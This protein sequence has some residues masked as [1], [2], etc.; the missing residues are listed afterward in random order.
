[1]KAGNI[2][3]SWPRLVL[4]A[5]IIPILCLSLS[6]RDK[7]T[8]TYAKSINFSNF[9]TYSWAEHGA[10]AHPL[11]AADIVAAIE[12]ELNARGLRK[13]TSNPDLIIQM[14]GSID[15]DMTMYS[16]DPLYG[17]TGGIP[18]FDPNLAGPVFIGFYGNTTVTVHKGQLVVDLIDA[19][20]KKLVWRGIAMESVSSHDPQKLVDEVNGAISKMFKQYPKEV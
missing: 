14:Y 13:A 8:V 15:Q 9:K 17:A 5:I 16:N 12:Q 18:P 7:I 6:A 4:V 10:V 11:L 19:K 20:A 2:I 1:M 3:Q